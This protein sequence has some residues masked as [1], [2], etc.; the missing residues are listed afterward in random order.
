VTVLLCGV[1]ADTG[2]VEPVPAIDDAGRFEYVP[3]PEKGPVHGAPT[4]GD[5]ERRHGDGV[6]GDVV[7]RV[8][9]NSTGPWI[10]DPSAIRTH[11]VHRDPNFAALTYGE[12]RPGYVCGLESLEPGDVVAFYAGLRS[13]ETGDKHRY[14]IGHFTLAKP[15]ILLEPDRPRRQVGEA[16]A[17]HPKNA[18]ARRFAGNGHL[19]YHDP[20]FDGRRKRVAVATGREPGR[21]LDRAVQLTD[22]REG[23][24]YYMAPAAE[25]ALSPQQGGGDGTYMGG[26]K[27]AIRCDVSADAFRTYL[28]ER[29]EAN[30]GRPS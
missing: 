9:P 10:D 26:I 29:A 21:R 7:E 3:I 14:L 16:L 12:H 1:G 27:P 24:G 20:T 4:Y 17:A 6:L 19:Y 25:R 11:P 15:S 18:H 13:L 5:L 22:R 28:A 30:A 2:N 8:R 23:P